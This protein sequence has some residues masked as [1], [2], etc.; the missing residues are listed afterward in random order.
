MDSEFRGRSR[1]ELNF[2]GLF[3][4]LVARSQR[5]GARNR[6]QQKGGSDGGNADFPRP[7]RALQG[8][9]ILPEIGDESGDGLEKETKD[10]AANPAGLI[11]HGRKMTENIRVFCATPAI[12][13]N[14]RA[15]RFG[16][17]TLHQLH[18]RR[19]FDAKIFHGAQGCAR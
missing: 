19:I 8:S 4:D 9:A 15:V 2:K 12:R 11:Q 18:Q 14:P 5:H 16:R 17:A 1:D 10:H 6:K 3:Q 13:N 7:G